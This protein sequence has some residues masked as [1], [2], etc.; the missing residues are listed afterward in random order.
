MTSRSRASPRTATTAR[1]SRRSTPSCRRGRTLD[2]R[3]AAGHRAAALLPLPRRPRR[4]RARRC[5]SS[6]A[7]R[8]R[9]DVTEVALPRELPR[10]HARQRRPD[11][12]RRPRRTSSPGSAPD[13]GA[14]PTGRWLGSV[15]GPGRRR[16]VARD[17]RQLRR[18][19]R[20]RRPLGERHDVDDADGEAAP[21]PGRR[22]RRAATL[23]RGA[24][25][26]P[27][28]DDFSDPTGAPDRFVP[29]P[30]PP[31]PTTTTDRMVAWFG[32]FGSP[33]ILLVSWSSGSGCPS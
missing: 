21:G 14:P 11:D 5:R 27:W 9:T 22:R 1:R 10:R 3:P 13:R 17:R 12:L 24:A 25:A 32:V 23:E 30:P 2:R 28:D 20:A 8:R 19:P 31:V 33:A 6:S 4:R 15:G 29:P 7:G 26:T 18:P 16:G